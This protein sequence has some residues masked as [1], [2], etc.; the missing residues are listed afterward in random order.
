MSINFAY[1][2]HIISFLGSWYC[3][4]KKPSHN[5][6]R[7]IFIYNII[8]FAFFYFIDKFYTI[9]EAFNIK[10]INYLFINPF[11]TIY[12]LYFFLLITRNSFAEK[13]YGRSTVFRMFFYLQLIA[14]IIDIFLQTMIFSY[15]FTNILIV[16]LSILF[17]SKEILPGSRK[18]IFRPEAWIVLG[19]L[20]FS[21][22][23]IPFTIY[24]EYAI[25]ANLKSD[26]LPVTYVYLFHFVNISP[27]TMFYAFLVV[28]CF[29]Y[30]TDVRTVS[31]LLK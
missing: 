20:L 11:T 9:T 17:F 30:L 28:G 10:N 7:K 6:I 22:T 25:M 29:K 26:N 5:L 19:Y 3:L 13:W 14:V 8:A 12:H 15:F 18:N 31:K 4:L 24:I 23:L 2:V 21:V 16:I 1:M 27:I